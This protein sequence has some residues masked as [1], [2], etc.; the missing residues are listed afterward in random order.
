MTAQTGLFVQQLADG[1]GTTAKGARQALA[2]LLAK[3]TDGTV[4]V[5]VLADGLGAVVTGAAGMSYSIRKH[6]AVTKVS[7]ANGPTLVANDG[8]VSVATDPAPGSNSRIDTIWVQQRHLAVDGGAD[9]V[10]TPLFGVAKGAAAASPSAPTIPT[11]ALELARVTVPSGTTATS[12]L[13]FT[14]GAQTS[15][16]GGRIVTAWTPL[17]LGNGWVVYGSGFRSPAWRMVGDEVQIRGS[18]K[19]GG[20]G[21]APAWILNVALPA[22]ARP[23]AVEGFVCQAYP[24]ACRIDVDTAGQLTIQI[25]IASGTNGHVSLDGIRFS[26]TD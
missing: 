1:S 24:G 13:T 9:T 2:G 3:N 19:S 14:Q 6:V 11:G 26:V 16:N 25:Y 4:K 5:G 17:T 18:I 20:G 21:V 7:E 10:N 15:A 12:G 22:T 8:T 23:S